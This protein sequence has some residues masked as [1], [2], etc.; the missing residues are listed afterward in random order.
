[1]ASVILSTAYGLDIKPANDPYAEL[2]AKAMDG[3]SKARTA[4]VYLVD[5][6]PFLRHLPVEHLP[7]VLGQWKRDGIEWRGHLAAMRHE[8]F[9]YS[10]EKYVRVP[11]NTKKKT[12]ARPNVVGWKT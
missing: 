1:M 4:G 2:V 5:I 7:G 10:A 3:L 12:W 11:P 9:R 8:P 6:L